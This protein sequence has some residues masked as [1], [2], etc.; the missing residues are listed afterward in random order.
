MEYLQTSYSTSSQEYPLNVW[1]DP[2]AYRKITRSLCFHVIES[3]QAGT[4][5]HVFE[6]KK[7]PFLEFLR[8]KPLSKSSIVR[9]EARG[10]CNGLISL[11]QDDGHVITSLVV[12]HPL[13]KECYE[14]PPFPL[15]FEKHMRRES[16]GLG[17]DAFTNTWKMVCV[18]LKE[19]SPPNKPDM[20]N[21]NL[22][23]MVHVFGTNSWR[24]IPKVPSYPVTGKTVFAN[25][26]LHWLSLK[27]VLIEFKERSK[28]EDGE[29]I[30]E[31]E[32]FGLI[33]PPKRMCDLWRKYSCYYDQLVDL[34]G[35]VG[36]V[37]SRTMEVWV[38]KQK[39]WVP[40]CRFEE[41]IVPD[42]YIDVMGCWNKDG[43]ILIKC[44]GNGSKVQDLGQ[45]RYIGIKVFY[46]E[47][48]AD[49]LD[50]VVL[51]FQNQKLVQKLESQKVECVALENKF[52]QLREKHLPYNKT[53]A[54]VDKSWDE[55]TGGSLEES[56]EA[57]AIAE[58]DDT[59]T[60]SAMSVAA[61]L[62][63][64]VGVHPT[65]CN[66]FDESGDPEK[67]FQA[68]LSLAKEGVEK[69]KVVAVGE[70]GLDYDRTHFCS[71]EIQ[72]KYFERQFELAHT[73]KLPM[74]L[75]M[76]AAASDFCDILEQNK[77]SCNQAPVSGSKKPA[78]DGQLIFLT[79]GDKLLYDQVTSYLDIMGKS[80][81]YLG[82]VGNGAA[83]KLVVN[84]IMGSMMTSFAE[85][86][87]LS[88]KV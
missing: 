1:L 42:G 18:L 50:T 39:E 60:E 9:I 78:E 45:I 68:L 49:L 87:L 59:C 86:L 75:H 61:R 84:M 48:M 6:P 40:H 54:V 63:C 28:P 37:C 29:K 12:I 8:M 46:I 35:E 55:V 20:L 47:H 64:T 19:Y 23:T 16:C 21:K 73:L 83:M 41:E 38:L 56:K 3:K 52:S 69:G 10:S 7:G 43:D 85:G 15:R 5:H 67:H 76:R 80:R 2:G 62:F 25:G 58:T 26:C 72:K 31:S 30:P 13:R 17:Y 32:E 65:R 14:L 57:L 81:F 4:T 70:C 74:F 24:E 34:N 71:P 77:H 88:E 27:M 36:Y 82:E 44:R 22:C 79:A 11:S 66:E 33:D 53:L 51:K